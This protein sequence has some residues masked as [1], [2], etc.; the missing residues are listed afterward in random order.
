[1][2]RKYKKRYFLQKIKSTSKY[3]F[4]FTVEYVVVVDVFM[5]KKS[6][7]KKSLYFWVP[8]CPIHSCY[9][10]PRDAIKHS[11]ATQQSSVG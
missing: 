2:N 4:E 7:R 6:E 5:N 3:T 10:F 8:S 1:M 9:F 11:L